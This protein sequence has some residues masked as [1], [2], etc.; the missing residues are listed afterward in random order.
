MGNGSTKYWNQIKNCSRREKKIKI[1]W[2]EYI[3]VLEV[4]YGISNTIVL[5]IPVYH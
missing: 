1:L 2:E 4:D 5:E 3:I